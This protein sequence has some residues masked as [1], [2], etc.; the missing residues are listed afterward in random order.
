MAQRGHS[1]PHASKLPSAVGDPGRDEI[2]KA[3]CYHF[4]AVYILLLY[5]VPL[6]SK[7]KQKRVEQLGII[8]CLFSSLMAVATYIFA[9]LI[10]AIALAGGYV[11]LYAC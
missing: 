4:P 8:Y 7:K 5:D 2:D 1:Q 3:A 9:A 11:Y 10:A 6:F